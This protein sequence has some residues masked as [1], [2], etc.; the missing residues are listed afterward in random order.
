[1]RYRCYRSS[2]NNREK[3][4]KKEVHGAKL[5]PARQDSR[6]DGNTEDPKRVM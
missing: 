5:I 1:M 3:S 4:I 6:E 2:T